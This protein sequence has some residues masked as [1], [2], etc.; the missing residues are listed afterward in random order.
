MEQK[1]I[2]QNGREF[3]PCRYRHGYV[4]GIPV[5][6]MFPSQEYLDRHIAE[7]HARRSN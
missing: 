2:V 1:K 4:N 6:P 7:Q 3:F 5:E